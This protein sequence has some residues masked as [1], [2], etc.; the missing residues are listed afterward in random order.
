MICINN[1]KKRH[2]KRLRTEMKIKKNRGAYNA[3][4]KDLTGNNMEGL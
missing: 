2:G 3:I 4:K 1:K